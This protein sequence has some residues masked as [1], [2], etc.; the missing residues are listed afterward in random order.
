MAK[1]TKKRLVLSHIYWRALCTLCAL[2]RAYSVYEAS[3][4]VVGRHIGC[5]II[6]N[7]N[8]C[9]QPEQLH[10]GL[11]CTITHLSC[12]CDQVQRQTLEI[13]LYYKK[14]VP[15]LELSNVLQK[16]VNRGRVVLRFSVLRHY[17]CEQIRKRNT[18]QI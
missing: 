7:S 16:L 11:T 17:L 2:Y 1:T 4:A 3:L 12:I 8:C 14:R 18:F 5:S 9:A 6:C 13:P 15:K 10:S